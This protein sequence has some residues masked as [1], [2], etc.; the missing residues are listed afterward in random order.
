LIFFPR[1]L[2]F[3][4]EDS[5]QLTPLESF[6]T[7]HFGLLLACAAAGLVVNIPSS[8][9]VS[10][11]EQKDPPAHPLIVPMT[12]FSLLSAFLSYNTTG[13]GS[14]PILYAICIGFMGVWGLWAITFAGPVSISRKTGANKHTSAFIFGNKSSA[15]E[16]KK[17]WKQEQRTMEH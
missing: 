13:A 15:S 17:R 5:Q 14:L 11:R 2:L 7:L 9:P 6:L 12:C 4:A 16:Q 8:F 10:T 3:A 1:I